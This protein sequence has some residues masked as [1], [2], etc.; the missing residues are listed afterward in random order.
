VSK[1]PVKNE[2]VNRLLMAMDRGL[3][4]CVEEFIGDELFKEAAA[5]AGGHWQDIL[6]ERKQEDES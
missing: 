4:C 3:R 6:D 1:N 2:L 5:E